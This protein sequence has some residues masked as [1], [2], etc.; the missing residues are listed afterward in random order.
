VITGGHP[1]DLTAQ[2]TLARAGT[3]AIQELA[4]GSWVT[5]TT[6][7]AAGTGRATASLTGLA[8]GNH[9]LRAW[10][11]GDGRGGAGTSSSITV[12]VRS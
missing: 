4:N 1:V 11:G 10:F 8:L 9:V 5:S 7:T 3:V 12:I 6:V 2:L